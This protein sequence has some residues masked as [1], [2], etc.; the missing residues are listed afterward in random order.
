[1]TIL[2]VLF[3][4][5]IVALVYSLSPQFTYKI[6]TL[7]LFICFYFSDFFQ[8]YNFGDSWMGLLNWIFPRIEKKHG[9]VTK[10]DLVYPPTPHP[11][12]N[13]FP[14]EPRPLE[15][16]LHPHMFLKHVKF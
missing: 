12:N 7:A 15:E 6:C 11:E 9:I 10:I 3:F 13:F 1:M 4:S 2:P 16:I 14:L 5:K 8:I